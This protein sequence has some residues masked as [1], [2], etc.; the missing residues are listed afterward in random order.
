MGQRL[1]AGGLL[2]CTQAGFVDSEREADPSPL[3]LFCPGA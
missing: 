3:T 2:C 1:L